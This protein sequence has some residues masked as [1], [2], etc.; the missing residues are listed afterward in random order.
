MALETGGVKNS[1]Q[2]SAAA[3]VVASALEV[4]A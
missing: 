2:A 1:P 3:G 4:A